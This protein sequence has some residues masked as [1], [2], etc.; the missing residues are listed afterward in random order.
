MRVSTNEY[1]LMIAKAV[2][3]RSTC[4]RRQ[5]GAIIVNRGEIIATGYNGS[6][7]GGVNCCDINHC[8][9]LNAP[10]NSGDYSECRA[11]HAEQNALLSAARRDMIGGTLYLFGIENDN[12]IDDAMPCPVCMKMIHNAGIINV[13][14]KGKIINV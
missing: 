3:S 8:P 11:V 6:I 2:A 13:I 5:Y 4:L 12:D 9:R 10:H 1:Y 7:R 14:T